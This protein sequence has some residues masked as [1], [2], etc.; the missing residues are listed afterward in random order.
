MAERTAAAEGPGPGSTGCRQVDALQGGL[1]E[2][3]VLGGPR[4][5][6]RPNGEDWPAA[7]DRHLAPDGPP[8]EGRARGDQA[9][10][11][12]AGVRDLLRRAR[13]CDPGAR[14]DRLW[15]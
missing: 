15:R 11:P 13:L 12:L 9:D 3:A 10:S 7:G 5:A 1:R 2:L 6:L 4:L 14:H 8:G